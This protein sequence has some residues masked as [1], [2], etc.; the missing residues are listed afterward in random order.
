MG[1]PQTFLA[2]TQSKK[3]VK[4]T[5]SGNYSACLVVAITFFSLYTLAGASPTNK[6][7]S[8]GIGNAVDGI[9]DTKKSL[10]NTVID[11]KKNIVK[12]IIELK[13]GI[14]KPII[15]AK[16]SIVRPIM[17]LKRGLIKTKKNIL[18][19][20]LTPVFNLKATG[21]SFIRDLLNTK[22]NLL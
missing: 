17:S 14:V 11:S 3:I 2:H 18:G 15:E 20:V 21:L 19:S 10:V 5:M 6:G 13:A 22:I 9:F 1:K 7:G 16:Q 4:V 12:P 8:A